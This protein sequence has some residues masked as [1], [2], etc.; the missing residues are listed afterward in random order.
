MQKAYG[1]GGIRA[2][3]GSAMATAKRTFKVTSVHHVT[4]MARRHFTLQ[5]K[6]PSVTFLALAWGTPVGLFIC[7]VI[8]RTGHLT[9]ILALSFMALSYG[10]GVVFAKALKA[11]NRYR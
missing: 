8:W 1:G 2:I 3:G 7:G 4:A 9:A 6:E 11:F 5:K 10:G